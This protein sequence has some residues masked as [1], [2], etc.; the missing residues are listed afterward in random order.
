MSRRM[1]LGACLGLALALGTGV[2]PAQA[3][4][5]FYL[6]KGL[7]TWAD[8]LGRSDAAS[9]RAAAFALGKLGSRANAELPQLL[10][11]LQGDKD[12]A[13]RETAAWAVG[14]VC[15]GNRGA[16]EG[17]TVLPALTQ[18]VAKDPD[19]LVRRSAAV[20]LGNVGLDVEALEE[21]LKDTNQTI[22]KGAE[23]LLK[24]VKAAQGALEQCLTDGNPAVRQNAA[25]ALG[26]LKADSV[27]PLRQ[28]LRKEDDTTVLR[29]TAKAVGQL[30][31]KGHAALPE[32]LLATQHKNTEVKKAA[33]GSLVLLVNSEDKEA[34]GPLQ[35]ALQD[36]NEEVRSNAAIALANIGGSGAKAALPVLL[37]DLQQ[38]TDLEKRRQAAGVIGNI[39]PDAKAAVAL[40]QQALKDPDKELRYNAAT[41]LGN[42]REAAEPAV[43]D[44]VQVVADPS[45][46]AELR[47]QAVLA[48]VTIGPVP[49]AK[50]ATKTLIDVVKDTRTPTEVRLRTMVALRHIQEAA[51]KD[52]P[53]LFQTLTGV[54]SQNITQENRVFLYN[55]SYFLSLYQRDKVPERVLDVLQAFLKDSSL[56][57]LEGQRVNAPGSNEKGTGQ[58]K[59]SD[60]KKSDARLLAVEALRLVGAERVKARRDI[61]AE[62][63]RLR[64]DRNTLPELQKAIQ[65]LFE[66]FSL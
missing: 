66:K 17:G 35:Q 49:A 54:V 33:L 18:A 64:D 3:Q 31:D 39:G 26:Q 55:S 56:A 9:R 63:R 48:L 36:G 60:V 2:G 51:L 40:L 20:A 25:W 19:P 42:L 30:G 11:L 32:L 57:L 65:T 46:S 22:R 43:P 29:D 58:A 50:A 41:S 27:T 23:Q 12:A 59:V 1:H 21:G 61:V 8:E 4:G 13:V 45:A 24:Q 6:G 47:T 5:A 38:K 15:K 53:E 62:L 37:K 10:K 7:R 34:Y 44:L 52:Y 28:M 14:E 16:A